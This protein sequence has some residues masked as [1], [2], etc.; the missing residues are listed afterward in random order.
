MSYITSRIIAMAYPE[1]AKTNFWRNHR[2][3]IVE[4]FKKKH[5]G[6]VKIYNL[7]IE[8]GFRIDDGYQK[9]FEC[10][11][12]ED[13][14]SKD[15][16]SC[17][18]EFP[19]LDHEPHKFSSMFE[20]DIDSSLYLSTSPSNNNAI[21]VHCK[22]GKGRTGVMICSLL[23]FLGFDPSLHDPDYPF[24]KGDSKQYDDHDEIPLKHSSKM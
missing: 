12:Y 13:F 22:A 1:N 5:N 2:P 9:D 18:C 17:L 24:H 14:R 10:N 3:K 21:A 20:F 8:K 16:T 6:K 23:V 7:C 11:A 4:F 15:V 19:C